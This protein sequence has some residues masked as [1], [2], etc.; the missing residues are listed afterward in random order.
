MLLELN[1]NVLL[2]NV[3]D[4]RTHDITTPWAS[5]GAK[6]VN[7]IDVCMYVDQVSKILIATII[8]L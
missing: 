1:I 2:N 4:T 8:I 3:S 7:S 5:V 6:K